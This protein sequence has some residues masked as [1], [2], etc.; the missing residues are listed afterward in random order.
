M[1]E[2]G[3]DA[4]RV[5]RRLRARRVTEPW[6]SNRF[7]EVLPASVWVLAIKQAEDGSGDTILRVQER[8]GTRGV[9]TIR[10]ALLKLDT[11]VALEPWQMKT[12]RIPSPGAG[13][14]RPQ[15]VS[16]LEL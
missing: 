7:L 16:L 14:G 11:S 2:G 15:E 12:L 3:P 6:T 8:S 1:R 9:A 5:R 4:R 13:R 10:S